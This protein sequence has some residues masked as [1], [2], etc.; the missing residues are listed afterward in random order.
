M[1]G[2]S[3]AHRTG[4]RSPDQER[5]TIYLPPE[6]VSAFGRLAAARDTNRN[7]V[8]REALRTYLAQSELLFPEEQQK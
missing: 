5:I 7:A 4:A 6:V 3:R 8:I 1:P 2:P